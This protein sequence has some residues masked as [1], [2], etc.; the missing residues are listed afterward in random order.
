MTLTS[1]TNDTNT[2][3]THAT[4]TRPARGMRTLKTVSRGLLAGTVIVIAF[5]SSIYFL[6]EFPMWGRQLG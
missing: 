3:S 5:G 2:T 6:A 4:A 1:D